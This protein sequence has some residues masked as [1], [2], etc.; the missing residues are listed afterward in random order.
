MLQLV[1]YEGTSRDDHHGNRRRTDQF[2][3]HVAE[4]HS[5]KRACPGRTRDDDV[6]VVPIALR[7]CGCDGVAFKDRR[8]NCDGFLSERV[9]PFDCCCEC[10]L[11]LLA[12]CEQH[13][14]FGMAAEPGAVDSGHPF[15]HGEEQ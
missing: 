13:L 7:Q 3:G 8:G 11:C 14:V 2:V 10:S 12:Q 5:P 9:D 1:G 6:R 15:D 4:E